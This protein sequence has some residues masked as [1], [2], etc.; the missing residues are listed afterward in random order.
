M[1]KTKRAFVIGLFVVLTVL[2]AGAD[3]KCNFFSSSD[4]VVFCS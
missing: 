4:C 2:I 3:G 1:Q